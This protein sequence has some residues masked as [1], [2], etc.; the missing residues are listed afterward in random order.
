[1]KG[2]PVLRTQHCGA[3]S[4]LPAKA[5]WRP[6]QPHPAPQPLRPV[7]DATAPSLRNCSNPTRLLSVPK[8]LPLPGLRP[9]FPR[10]IPLILQ[11]R[12]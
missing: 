1:M 8:L 6:L 3:P 4:A 10:G 7:I 11:V 5:E 12:T 9:S 2:E